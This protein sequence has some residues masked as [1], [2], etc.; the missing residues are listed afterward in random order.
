MS[1]VGFSLSRVTLHWPAALWVQLAAVLLFASAYSAEDPSHVVTINAH[2]SELAAEVDEAYLSFNIEMQQVVAGDFW[3]P[4]EGPLRIADPPFDFSRERLRN[5]T[6]ALAPAVIRVSG[7]GANSTYFDIT[8]SLATTP[9]PGFLYTLTKSQWDDANHFAM[10]MGMEVLVS[11]GVSD[12]SRD[13]DRV[14]MSANARELLEYTMDQS[15]PLAGLSFI[16]EPF[17]GTL[18]GLPPN[19]TAAEFGRDYATFR[20]LRDEV[21]PSVPIAGPG[22]VPF[23]ADI[24]IFDGPD[25]IEIMEEV[26]D[27]F[28]AIDYH[29][30]AA[31]S[32]RCAALGLPGL[33]TPE[34]ALEP[35]FLDNGDT[36]FA[37]TADVRDTYSP[38]SPIW[39]T[40]TAGAGCGGNV[41]NFAFLDTFRFVNQLG[42]RAQQGLDQL[43]HNTLTGASYGLLSEPDL[44]ISANYWAAVLWKRL[45]GTRAL[46]PATTGPGEVRVYAHCT[47]D[48]PS[49]V[50]HVVINTDRESSADVRLRGRG[51]LVSLAYVLTAPDLMGNEV[52]LNGQALVA[53]ADGHLPHLR[54]R[55]VVG[56]KDI[57]LPPTSIA[58]I[59]QPFARAEAC[60]VH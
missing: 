31:L 7:T 9:P 60:G 33:T 58:F 43:Y 2:R 16:N 44:E 45:M 17:T 56:R 27:G 39:L 51:S 22:T 1:S 42:S 24:P 3:G 53:S 18:A 20:A 57:T 4:I 8:D 40:E 34:E 10:D 50:T 35:E 46:A 54:P 26:Q 37:F 36:S 11:V 23:T 15:Y 41:W 12:G 6:Q 30:Y 29:F 25:T 49:S 21:A 47:G 13:L 38:D 14:W 52:E 48:F 55:W 19:Y 32:D 28:D 59:V 5:L